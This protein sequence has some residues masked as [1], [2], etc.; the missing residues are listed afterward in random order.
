MVTRLA[1]THATETRTWP[2]PPALALNPQ[3]PPSCL[4]SGTGHRGPDLR[5]QELP[6]LAAG[7]GR[8][9]GAGRS[10]D[11]SAGWLQLLAR[12]CGCGEG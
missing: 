10:G 3:P 2:A 11:W 7:A 9:G 4:P 8:H 5:G 1:P 12:V 6:Q